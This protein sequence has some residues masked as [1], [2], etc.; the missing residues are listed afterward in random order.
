MIACQ[1]TLSN[2]TIRRGDQFGIYLTVKN[3]FNSDITVVKTTMF[4]MLKEID[5][6]ATIIRQF[7]AIGSWTGSCNDLSKISIP[8][9]V[10]TGTEDV[11]VPSANSLIIVQ[12]ISGAWLVQINGAGHGLMYQYPEQF[13]KILQ[14]FLDNT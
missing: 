9:L 1:V 10:I 6:P 3:G 7:Q 13:N 5:P 8:T 2:K 11:V 14:T 12:K 4:G